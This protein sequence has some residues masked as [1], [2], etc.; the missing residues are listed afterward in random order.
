VGVKVSS[1]LQPWR[2]TETSL[3][4]SSGGQEL[5]T[6]LDAAGIGLSLWCQI[7]RSPA[8]VPESLSLNCMFIHLSLLHG[9]Q[10]SLLTIT[11]Y[12]GAAHTFLFPIII[13]LA[14][15]QSESFIQKLQMLVQA[16]HRLHE[17]TPKCIPKL[18]VG[19]IVSSLKCHYKKFSE[20]QIK[21]QR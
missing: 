2:A 10:A 1:I 9:V 8:S 17:S 13:F 6:F 11:G 21:A 19:S 4:A 7:A 20:L 16:S 15:R 12:Y 14:C 18:T 3:A 5:H